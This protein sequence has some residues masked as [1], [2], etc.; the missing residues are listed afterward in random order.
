MSEREL[1]SRLNNIQKLAED[2]GYNLI[3]WN[4]RCLKDDL[5]EPYYA[6]L[7]YLN[8]IADNQI[9]KKFDKDLSVLP[10]KYIIPFKE[11]CKESEKKLDID[12]TFKFINLVVKDIK[13]LYYGTDIHS[14]I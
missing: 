6:L 9:F 4:I 11:Y 8:D 13:Q 2:Y 1:F 7:S 10:D 14:T 12:K 3:S 5:L